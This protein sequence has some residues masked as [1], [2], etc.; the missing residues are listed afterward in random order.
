MKWARIGSGLVDLSRY[1]RF[2]VEPYGGG[3]NVVGYRE[4]KITDSLG[5]RSL[6]VWENVAQFE[7]E[8]LA[9]D[10]LQSTVLDAEFF[11]SPASQPGQRYVLS[12]PPFLKDEI[13]ER[14]GEIVG[15][16]ELTSWPSQEQDCARLSKEFPTVLF[17]LESRGADVFTNIWRKYFLNG[18]RQFARAKI[19]FPDMDAKG[20]WREV[21]CSD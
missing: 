12:W 21:Q 5:E 11:S 9:R 8:K 15:T 17:T 13:S 20:E 4:R 18:K 14:A 2:K 7:N 1:I 19:V 3:V 10:A 6:E 16:K